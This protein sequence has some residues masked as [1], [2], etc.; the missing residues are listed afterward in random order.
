MEKRRTPWANLCW[1]F[2]WTGGL[3]HQI[4]YVGELSI[5]PKAVKTQISL[6]EDILRTLSMLPTAFADSFA[7]RSDSR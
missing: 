6:E 5:L 1:P 7:S 4:F 2:W 3:L